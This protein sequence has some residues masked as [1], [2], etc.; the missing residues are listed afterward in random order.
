MPNTGVLPIS[1]RMLACCVCSGSGSPGPFERNTPSGASAST[2]SAEVSAG[3]TVTRQP[4]CTS[5]R[6]MFRLIPKSYA[7]TW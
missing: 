2:S 7:T 3:T 1:F 6:R 4:E 5:R